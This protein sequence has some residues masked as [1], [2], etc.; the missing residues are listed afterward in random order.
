MRTKILDDRGERAGDEL[1]G[2]NFNNEKDTI[3]KNLILRI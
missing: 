1:F 3:T 2:I